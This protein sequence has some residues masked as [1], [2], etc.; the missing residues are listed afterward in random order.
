MPGAVPP[1]TDPAWPDSTADQLVFELSRLPAREAGEVLSHLPDED[2]VR[3]LGRLPPAKMN[4]V[5]ET[6]S[7]SRRAALVAAFPA[8]LRVQWQRSRSYPPGS[9]GAMMRL[10]V[11]MLPAHCR[12]EDAIAELRRLVTAHLITYLY[13][14]DPGGRLV[15]VV[16]LRDLFL[17]SPRQTLADIMIRPAFSLPPDLP[18]LE[19]MR[20]VV[21]RHYP[22]YPVCESDGRLV[23]LVRG[24][25]LFENQAIAIS[26]MPGRMEGVRS[27]E[28]LTTPFWRSLRYR[29]PWLLLNLGLSLGSA[30]VVTYY[31]DAVRALVL[32]AVFLPVIAAQARNS[33]AQTMAITLRGLTHGDWTPGRTRSLL[34]KETLLGLVTGGLIGL[35]A[36]GLITLQAIQQGEPAPLGLGFVLAGTM[37]VSCALAGTTGVAVP[38]VLRR[39]GADPAL[40]S[41]IILTTIASVV[42][43]ALFLGVAAWCLL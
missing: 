12:V 37:A 31:R 39:F 10:P 2:A 9:I 11:G 33:G 42:S 4:E 38:L 23:G 26:A 40:A 43:Q 24:E 7:E 5:L 34:A 36:G 3:L 20:L 25:A 30:A 28:G 32:L 15:G 8:E 13:P 35:L 27:H 18:A 29:S 1:G 19:A 41:S 21:R 17:A 22:V 16:V 6:Y 14:V